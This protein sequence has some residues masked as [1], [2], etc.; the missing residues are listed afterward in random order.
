MSCA[1]F[2]TT[3][4]SG[5]QQPDVWRQ[6]FEKYCGEYG[7]LRDR[8]VE[9]MLH[10]ANG[11]RELW[12]ALDMADGRCTEDWIMEVPDLDLVEIC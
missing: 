2:F 11:M 3:D 1:N 8:G 10:Q 5:L 7:P 4:P 6:I 12:I 9:E